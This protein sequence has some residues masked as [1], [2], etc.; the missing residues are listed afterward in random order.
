MWTT[1]FEYGIALTTLPQTNEM[2]EAWMM[3]FSEYASA[4]QANIYNW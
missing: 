1:V 3:S 4:P 2:D